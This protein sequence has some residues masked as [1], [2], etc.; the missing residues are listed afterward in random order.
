M[1]RGDS[2]VARRTVKGNEGV[3]KLNHSGAGSTI[4]A[5]AWSDRLSFV[6]DTLR[7]WRVTRSP[8]EGK[9]M[10]LPG[11]GKPGILGTILSSDRRNVKR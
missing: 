1:G 8:T 3:V 7:F 5:L 11:C 2:S 10:L 4:V 6:E 9:G